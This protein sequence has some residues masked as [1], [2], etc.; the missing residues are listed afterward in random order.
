M[1]SELDRLLKLDYPTRQ[2]MRN[3]IH[4]QGKQ[5]AKLEVAAHSTSN[6][7]ERVVICSG[8]ICPYC[9]KFKTCL[10]RETYPGC[11]TCC[12]DFV[13]RKLTPVS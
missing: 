10:T 6:N 12:Y 2:D 1:Q 13:G 3:I 5:I 9:N 8:S 4:L 11:R 7:T